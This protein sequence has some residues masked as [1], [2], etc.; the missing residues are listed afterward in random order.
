MTFVFNFFWGGG[1]Y[2]FGVVNVTFG[3][4]ILNPDS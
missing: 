4:E 2:Y 1:L 3:E